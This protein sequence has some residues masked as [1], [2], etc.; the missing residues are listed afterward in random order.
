MADDNI[1]ASEKSDYSLPPLETDVNKSD[2]DDMLEGN[3]LPEKKPP[4]IAM[5]VQPN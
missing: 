1:E 3:I 4:H 5:V 2:E